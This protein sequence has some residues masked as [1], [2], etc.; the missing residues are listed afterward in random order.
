MR[1]ASSNLM[2]RV[3]RK[4]DS[5]SGRGCKL[6]QVSGRNLNLRQ[7]Y[8]QM[9][10]LNLT[11]LFKMKNTCQTLLLIKTKIIKGDGT[12]LSDSNKVA[13]V[14]NFLHSMFSDCSVYLNQKLI[15]AYVETL[16]N[17]NEE[18]KK[19]YLQSQLWYKDDAGEMDSCNNDNTGWVERHDLAAKGRVVSMIGRLHADILCQ[20]KLSPNGIAMDIK[21][22]P[23]KASFCLMSSED[24]AEYKFSIL[25]ATLFVRKCKN[26]PTG[27][28]C[29]CNSSRKVPISR[30]EMKS[31]TI[32][33]NV[34]SKE[35]P[36]HYIGQLPVRIIAFLVNNSA[37]NGILAENPY[38]V[39][40]FDLNYL[41]LHVDGQQIPSTPLT[42]NYS[43][44]DFIEAYYSTILDT[45][46]QFMDDGHT[47]ET[48]DYNDGYCFYC[49]ALT[50]D[51]SAS[52]LHWQL[53][54]SGTIRHVNRLEIYSYE[55]FNIIT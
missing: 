41:S 15:T 33:S 27:G 6:N 34:T 46:L 5:M 43:S 9:L 45:Y 20:T 8:L 36:N 1:E 17:Y 3:E 2:E 49:F 29:A 42:P 51:Q 37:A 48:S 23:A 40:H 18:P 30:V 14:N 7:H 39:E 38:N 11:F 22:T 35:I 19:L 24:N 12:T 10:L 4:I 25:D 13:P 47:I 26:K 21:L 54:K 52:D 31:V 32:P 50:A 16:F 53:R 44:G 55:Q 28:N